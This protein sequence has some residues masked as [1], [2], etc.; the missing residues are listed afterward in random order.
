L[1]ASTLAAGWVSWRIGL[2]CARQ[3]SRRPAIA[4]VVVWSAVACTLGLSEWALRSTSMNDNFRNLAAFGHER[5]PILGFEQ[6]AN[7]LWEQEGVRMSTDARRFR[8][9]PIDAPDSP[10]TVASI[11]VVGGSSAFGFGLDD[12][13]T[14]PALLERRLRAHG[15]AIRVINAANQGHNSYQTLIR[16]YLRVLPLKPDWVLFYGSRNDLGSQRLP[17]TG[18]FFPAEAAPWSTHEFL[19]HR[20]PEKNL[21]YRSLLVFIAHSAFRGQFGGTDWYPLHEPTEPRS[22]HEVL[23]ANAATYVRNLRTLLDTCRR[24]GVQPVLAT[25]LFDED[26]AQGPFARGLLLNN[27]QLA[28]VA[29]EEGVPLIDLATE[30]KSV[31]GK[32]DYFFDDAYHPNARGAAWIAASVAAHFERWT[33]R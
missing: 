3:Q 6:R 12:S 5:S 25:F 33:A 21:Y 30:F 22:M 31:E 7:H 29:H 19:D 9:R 8:N 26:R 14:W 18:A 2:R 16:T 11:A 4:F 28:K 23:V 10:I 32:Q 15:R 27:E 13:Q 17:P 24:A 20:Y 1:L